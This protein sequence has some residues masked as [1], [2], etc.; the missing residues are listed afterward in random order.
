MPL[1]PIINADF[2]DPDIVRVGDT[3]YM[4]STTMFFMPGGDILRSYDLAHWEIVG[5][6]FADLGE[7]DRYE[8]ANG[9]NVYS[10]GMW[11][12]SIRYHD[13]LFYVTFACNEKRK[14]LLYTAK[15]PLGEWELT[16][17]DDFYHDASLF[18]D[19]D[20]RVYIVSG[21]TT[22]NIN[23]LDPKTWKKKEGGLSKVLIEDKKGQFLGYEG[24][25]LYKYNGKYYLFTCHMPKETDGRKT[26]DCFISDS[27]EGSFRGKLIL[28]DCMGY[29]PYLQVAQGGMVDDAYGNLYM[30]MFQDRGAIG[31]APVI[32]P[33]RF[34]DDGY[35]MPDTPDG[36]V[37]ISFEGCKYDPAVNDRIRD[38][39]Y[40]D[41]DFGYKDVDDMLASSPWWQISHNPDK[42]CISFTDRH[43]IKIKTN[44]TVPNLLH[45]RNVF[46]VRCMGPASKASVKIDVSGL[47][48]GDYAG[49]AVY[50]AHYGSLAV[51]KH[52]GK[53]ELVLVNADAAN[54]GVGGDKGFFDRD[55]EETVIDTLDTGVITLIANADFSKERDVSYFEYVK[56]GEKKKAGGEHPMY[57]KL[58]MFT[59]CRFA[60]FVY[61]KEQPGGCAEFSDYRM[62][63]AE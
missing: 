49:I 21:N 17:L 12:P 13:G 8:L 15:D 54:P 37:P 29:R 26:E 7:G 61:S 58:D 42:G 48:E 59:G 2:P 52:D 22:I 46:T 44:R 10:R 35:P 11:A 47:N 63:V 45:A 38:L 50:N 43:S 60:L 1:N 4:I 20:G 57:F 39:I 28:N 62:T 18:F 34:D 16:E 41:D 19:D 6:I 24:C 51:R 25:H 36:K 27:L 9:E 55:P 40:A 5:H 3:F 33:M 30:F 32:M 23:E 56:A 14:S 53:N 31:R